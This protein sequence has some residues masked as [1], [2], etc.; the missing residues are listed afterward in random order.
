MVNPKVSI[1]IP[2]YNCETT[3]ERSLSSVAS[4]TFQDFEVVLVLNNCTDKTKEVAEK[5]S[6]I[7]SLKIYES[8]IPGIVPTL[9]AGIF[10]CSAPL[11]ARQDGDDFWYPKKLEKQI[12]FLE[13]NPEVDILGTQIRL[14]DQGFKPVED[15]LVHPQEDMPIKMKLLGGNNAVAHPSVIFKKSIFLQA[16]IY[17]DNYRF[18]EDYFLWLKCI[19]WHKFANLAD[20]M[21]D[22]TISHNPE[23]DPRIPQYACYNAIQ[24]FK[25]QGII[26]C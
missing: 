4:Q 16:G 20:I 24:M 18:A 8:H 17:E 9:N 2:A 7:F 3:L 12:E 23:Y 26:K 15:S 5:F 10:H 6:N 13:K 11:I 1:L 21:V 25:Q 22:Y 19:R 14:V